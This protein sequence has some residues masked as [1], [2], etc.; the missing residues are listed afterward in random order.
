MKCALTTSLVLLAPSALASAQ[1]AD[2]RGFPEGGFGTTVV[3]GGITFSNLQNGLGGSPSFVYEQA[4]GTLTGMAGFTSPMT[5][6]FSGYSPGPGAAF[7]R[8]ISFDMSAG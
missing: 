2:L 4:D 5:L 7:T 6:G 3:D 8:V 1:T